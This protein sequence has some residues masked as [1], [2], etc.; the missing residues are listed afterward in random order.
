MGKRPA[1]LTET[2]RK[3]I[4]RR[5]HPV[6][7]SEAAKRWMKKNPHLVA[8]RK[9]R[10]RH[11]H[12]E[13]LTIA[14]R[15][16]RQEN[17]ARNASTKKRWAQNNKIHLTVMAHRRRAKQFA[18]DDG[19]ITPASLW[20]L[21]DQHPTCPYCG[22][23]LCEANRSLDHKEPLSLGGL[24]TLSNVIPCCLTCNL[25][26]HDKPYAFW[27]AELAKPTRKGRG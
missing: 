23:M 3:R 15:T 5:E 27:M 21:Y 18:T 20:S 4:W 12:A 14:A 19:T 17:A 25:R 26:K 11:K 13:Q 2:E 9:K 6:S 16:W 8:A 24:H 10:Y 7:A 1:V 22:F